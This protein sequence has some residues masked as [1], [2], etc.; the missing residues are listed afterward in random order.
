MSRDWVGG[1]MRPG[2]RLQSAP[3]PESETRGRSRYALGTLPST[4]MDDELR[5]TE[6]R[7]LLGRVAARDQAARNE[8]VRRTSANLERLTHKLLAGYPTVRRWE[9]TDDVVQNASLRLMRALEQV[10]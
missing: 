2:G 6:L 1:S 7:D 3:H 4:D 9:Q 10:S 5:T 8:L